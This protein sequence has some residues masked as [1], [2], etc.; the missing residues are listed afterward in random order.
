MTLNGDPADLTAST[1]KTKEFPNQLQAESISSGLPPAL[2]ASVHVNAAK[3]TNSNSSS[4]SSGSTNSQK[5]ELIKSKLEIEFFKK[6]N[7]LELDLLA[8]NLQRQRDLNKLHLEAVKARLEKSSEY[9][10]KEAQ[11]EFNVSVALAR[12]RLR[13]AQICQADMVR[14]LILSQT[15]SLTLLST[16]CIRIT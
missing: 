6:R 15:P 3:P 2:L 5:L 13:E 4:P 8:I 7:E 1:L 16:L 11:L 12:K 9:L 10:E 14:F